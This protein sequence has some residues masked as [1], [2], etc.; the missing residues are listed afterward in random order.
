MENLYTDSRADIMGFV[1]NCGISSALATEMQQFCTKLS[2]CL[3]KEVF[4]YTFSL[5][6]NHDLTILLHLWL[7]SNNHT[8][9]CIISL[10]SSKYGRGLHKLNEICN[11]I[12]DKDE[13]LINNWCL[14]TREHGKD[15][16]KVSPSFELCIEYC[17]LPLFEFRQQY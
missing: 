10:C 16:G 13:I 5:K 6:K 8:I 15:F 7:T 9:R 3:K 17:N 11:K 12:I 2:R 4:A 14:F 1:Q